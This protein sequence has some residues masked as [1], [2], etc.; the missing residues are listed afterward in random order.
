MAYY[1]TADGGTESLRARIYDLEGRCL[2]QR[3]VPYE[4]RFAPG[5]R[6]EQDPED[7]WRALVA[8]TAGAIAEA[9]VPAA[10]IEAMCYATTC[11]TVVALDGAGR[12]LRPALLWMD[13][14][15]HAE[16]DAVLATGDPALKVNGAGQGPV[17]AEW[18]IPKALWLKRNEPEVF[19]AAAT[20]CEY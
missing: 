20:I 5:A 19:A 14:R 1:L 17:S 18:M 11:C 13:V 9:G 4:T 8:A 6:A 12:A 2:G 7:W 16:A 3:A 10:E 15:A